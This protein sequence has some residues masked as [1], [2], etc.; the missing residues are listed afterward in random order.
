MLPP[1]V[2]DKSLQ[3]LEDVDGGEPTYDSRL[4]ATIHR[5][6]RVLLIACTWATA[7]ASASAITIY[8][9]E[10]HGEALY[11]LS[12]H[13]VLIS[14]ERVSAKPLVRCDV[15]RLR[16]GRLLAVTSRAQKLGE[17]YSIQILRVTSSAKQKLSET[18]P[19]VASV[20]I[21]DGS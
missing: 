3:E 5:L 1:S 6:R 10:P 9:G 7:C 19:P 12:R 13:A 8:S 16:D 21:P 11:D 18:L 20:A 4:V 2:L 14:H 15:F 17:P